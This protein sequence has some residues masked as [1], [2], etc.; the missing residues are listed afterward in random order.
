VK[1]AELR[2]VRERRFS[3]ALST[4]VYTTTSGGYEEERARVHVPQGMNWTAHLRVHAPWLPLALFAAG[5][6]HMHHYQL[7]DIDASEGRLEPFTVRV[8]E[9]GFDAQEALEIAKST[10]ATDTGRER[11]GDAQAVLALFQVGH[12]TGDATFSDDWAD[13]VLAKLLAR[14]PTGRMTGVSVVRESADYPALSGE[15]VTVKGYC[16]R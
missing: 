2:S 14:C 13:G 9:T 6:A 11:M 16:I 5:C 8:D 10:S 1:V 12:E 3:R 15:I 4:A 7:G